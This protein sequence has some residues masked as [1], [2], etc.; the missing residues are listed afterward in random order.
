MTMGRPFSIPEQFIK[1]ELPQAVFN[2]STASLVPIDDSRE[3]AGVS[4]FTATM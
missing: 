4:F 1:V 2:T 3:L